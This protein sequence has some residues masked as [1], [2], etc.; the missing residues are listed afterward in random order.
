VNRLHPLN[1]VVAV[2]MV[3][4]LA[5]FAP[6]AG[7]AAN[8][9]TKVQAAAAITAHSDFAKCTEVADSVV[10]TGDWAVVPHH[11]KQFPDASGTAILHFT[12]GNWVY[13]CGH[14]DDVM[15]A[16][17][18]ATQCKTSISEALRLGFH[19]DNPALYELSDPV[20]AVEKY[21]AL[22]ENRQ[23]PATYAMLSSSYQAAHPY[24]SWL[25]DHVTTTGIWVNA[26]PG[27]TGSLINVKIYSSEKPGAMVDQ[28]FIGTWKL[29][30]VRGVWK[31]DSVELT[32]TKLQ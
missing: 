21:Y 30:N 1:R 11:C 25:K 7:L 9:L 14:G 10:Q 13:A 28:A 26:S 31:L 8:A 12:D 6:Q 15:P 17:A 19:P 29:V 18:V 2:A 20:Q 24:A 16:E 4:I 3:T 5:A 23:Y 32:Q 27:K 22:W